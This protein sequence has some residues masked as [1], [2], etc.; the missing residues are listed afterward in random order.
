MQM[1]LFGNTP[2]QWAIDK[3]QILVAELIKLW[4]DWQG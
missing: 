3:E 4:N 2:E 1:V